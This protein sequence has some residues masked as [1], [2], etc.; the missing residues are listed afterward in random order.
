MNTN[1]TSPVSMQRSLDLLA[2]AAL[3]PQDEAILAWQTWRA[4]YD[5]DTTPW[6]EVR[7]L[8]AVASRIEMLEP[9]AAIRPRVLGIRKFLWVNSQICLKNAISGLTALNRADIL[10]LLMKGAARIARNPS[11]AQERLIR[12]VDIL[13][14]LGRE[15]D[16]FKTLEE[17]GWSLVAE[18]W[19]ISWRR[20]AP[21]AG[22]H[23]WSLAKKKSE[24]DLHHFS[25]FL[26]RLRGD[27]DGFWARSIPIEW[28]GVKVLVPSPAD[29]LVIALIHGVRWSQDSAADWTIDSSALIDE[30]NVDWQIFLEE[31]RRRK[32]QTALL[33]G[34]VYLRDAL[35]KKIPDV[36]ITKLGAEATPAQQAELQ[37]YSSTAMS[38]TP[39]NI[40]ASSL[41]AIQRALSHNKRNRRPPAP[42]LPQPVAK[43]LSIN[44][45]SDTGYS[46]AVPCAQNNC[47]VLIVQAVINW[48]GAITVQP[49]QIEFMAPGLPLALLTEKTQPDSAQTFTLRLPE[50]LLD[51][52]DIKVLGFKYTIGNSSASLPVTITISRME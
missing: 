48:P 31:A 20:W 43:R 45:A 10:V 12:D 44:L 28:H 34:L 36:V 32:I 40:A 3:A 25:N 50:V 6:S 38:A 39:K 7:M 42:Q 51:L 1:Q 37:Q 17:D 21:V 47:G 29:A 2:R 19:Q 23:A 14:P 27:D 49:V 41:M 22:H 13:V 5:I 52:R 16:A 11:C 18:D 24:I 26:N 46:F 15:Q 33:S 30:G 8:G 4:A 9:D 35:H